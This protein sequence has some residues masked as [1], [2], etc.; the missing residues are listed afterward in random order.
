MLINA[1]HSVQCYNGDYG[2]APE[3]GMVDHAIRQVQVNLAY[4]YDVATGPSGSLESAQ[5]PLVYLPTSL[6][7]DV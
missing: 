6:P 7:S 3:N 5:D 4:V 1:N 2:K